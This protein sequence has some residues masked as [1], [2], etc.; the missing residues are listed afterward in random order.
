VTFWAAVAFDAMAK[1][2]WWI[3]GCKYPWMLK[4]ALDE[5]SGQ[6]SLDDQACAGECRS[7]RGR[8]PTFH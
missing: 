7:N 6:Q 5:P 3:L 2:F 8:Y 4:A 1:G